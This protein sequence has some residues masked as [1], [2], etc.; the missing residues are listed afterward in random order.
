[1]LERIMADAYVCPPRPDS[2]GMWA[3]YRFLKRNDFLV[4]TSLDGP[5]KIRDRY[6]RDCTGRSTYD[7]VLPIVKGHIA[8]KDKQ[9]GG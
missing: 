9:Q 1:M 3:A 8:D 6:R 5:K 4:G 2:L 7:R